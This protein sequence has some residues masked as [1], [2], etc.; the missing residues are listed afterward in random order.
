MK[1]FWVGRVFVK[2]GILRIVSKNNV[3]GASPF[4]PMVSFIAFKETLNK[5]LGGVDG[6]SFLTLL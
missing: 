5:N 1:Y 3:E 2:I 6:W 4:Y